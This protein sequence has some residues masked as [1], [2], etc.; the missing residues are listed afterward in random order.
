MHSTLRSLLAIGLLLASCDTGNNSQGG[1]DLRPI[2]DLRTGSGNPTVGLLCDDTN[3]CPKDKSGMPARCAVV[4]TGDPVGVCAPTCT[5]N[6]DCDTGLP[7]SAF[8][9]TMPMLG[10]SVS[11]CV[12]FCNTNTKAC[13]SGWTCASI[14]GYFIC[15]PPQTKPHYDGGTHD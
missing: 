2:P 4:M 14:Q 13:P 10:A 9:T 1:Q 8:C 15:R 3:A 6:T 5:T 7:G 11:E 12:L